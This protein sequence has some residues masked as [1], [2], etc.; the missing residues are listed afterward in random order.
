MMYDALLYVN[1]PFRLLIAFLAVTHRLS[2][3]G[4]NE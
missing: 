2:N 4:S 3:S 1:M